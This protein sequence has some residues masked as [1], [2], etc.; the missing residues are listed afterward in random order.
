M[1]TSTAPKLNQSTRFRLKSSIQNLL[2]PFFIKIRIEKRETAIKIC[3]LIPAQCPFERDVSLFGHTFF[4]IPPLCK[5]NPAYDELVALR[6]QAL[7]FLADQCGEDI[8][9]FCS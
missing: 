1:I 5:L 4:H 2:H 7:S 9:Q 8:S 3:K 6:F